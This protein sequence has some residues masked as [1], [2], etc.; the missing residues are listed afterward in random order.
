[1]QF[2]ENA[3][4]PGYGNGFMYLLSPDSLIL[5]FNWP[6]IANG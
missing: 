4:G 5:H 1:M 6:S 2:D 3:L